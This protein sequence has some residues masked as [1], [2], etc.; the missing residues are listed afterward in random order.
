MKYVGVDLHKQSISLCVVKIVRGA[1]E[2][3]QR[4]RLS[5][6]D[7]AAI[8]KFF[9]GL[10][11]FQVAVEATSSYEWFVQLVEPLAQR[12][13]LVHPKKLRV[14]AESTRKTDKID[15]QVLAEFLSQDML[16]RAWRPTPRVREHRVLVRQR[17]YLTRRIT[18]VK[19]K[20][21]HVLANY[22]WDVPHLFSAAGQEYLRGLKLRS[23]DRF[24]VQQLQAELL[25][26]QQRLEAIDTELAEFAARGPLAE[27][28]AR[29]LLDSVPGVG[30]VTI[31]VVLSELGDWRRFRSEKDVASYAGLAPGLRE[32][33]GK[34]HQL[35]I[36]KEGSRLLRWAMV[37]LAWRLVGKSP[38][39]QGIYKRLEVRCGA[40]KAIVA[41]ARRLLGVLFAVL[42]T[43][44]PYAL[45]GKPQS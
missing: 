25:E 33:A 12:V 18:G 34:A 20:L 28:E 41:V 35:G 14:I 37:Q 43:G 23:A 6:A 29:K 42:R 26:Q 16:P 13:V 32:S 19:N 39:W 7:V 11:K 27:R 8:P 30:P 15:A 3:E 4:R 2:V 9:T 24:V 22:N 1:R 36:T 21:R 17:Y 5:C 45:A 38:R 44:Q 31:D 10:R 40:K